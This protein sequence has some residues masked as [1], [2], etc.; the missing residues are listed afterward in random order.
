[1]AKLNLDLLRRTPAYPFA[2]A[3]HY[4]DM[5][6]STLRTWCLGQGYA[7]KGSRRSF[8][9]LIQLDGRFGEGLSFLNLVEAHVLAAIRRVHGVPLPTVRRALLFVGETL[10][11]KRPLADLEFQTNG[12]DL[13]VKELNRLLNVSKSGQVEMEEFL[14]AH[15]KR[16]ERDPSGVPIKLFPFTRKSID[17]EPLAPI[18]IDPRV[19]FGRPVL[20]GKAVPT[21]VLADRFKAGDTLQELAGDYGV[22]TEEIEEAIRCEFDRRA[23]A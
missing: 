19:S 3:S 15:L 18:E 2:E 14:R 4:L 21:A 11:I 12:V 16:V 22:P 9:R 10:G 13:F 7:Y 5:P 23:A 17:G 1:M 8:K 6:V 20:R